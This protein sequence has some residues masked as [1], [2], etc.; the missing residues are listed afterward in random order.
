M[1]FV[2]EIMTFDFEIVSQL[3][4]SQLK[5]IQCQWSILFFSYVELTFS[6][7]KDKET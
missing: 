6:R 3:M 1:T 7:D 5:V 2:L 4:S